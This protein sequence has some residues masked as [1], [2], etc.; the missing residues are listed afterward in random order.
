M[1]R[2]WAKLTDTL[3]ETALTEDLGSGDITTNATIASSL[4]S[5][6]YI[7]SKDSGVMAGI[8]VSMKVFHKVDNSLK[9]RVLLKDGEKFSNGQKI[10]EITGSVASIFKAERTALNFLGRI[11]GIATLTAKYVDKVQGCHAKILDTRKTMP[12]MRHLD[13]YAVRTGGGYN[14]RFGLYDRVLIKDNHIA[15]VGGIRIAVDRVLSHMKKCHKNTKIEVECNSYDEVLEAVYTPVDIIM[16]DNMD[17]SEIER[18]VKLINESNA[19][20]ERTIRIEIS[21][22]INLDTVRAVA[23]TGVDYISIGILTHSV[24]NSDFTLLFDEI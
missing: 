2:Q 23:E 14:H 12:T 7:F 11:T 18:T 9:T 6:A 20:N 4:E 17:L 22:N 24:K 13:K 10:A 21:G 16:L 5:T 19:E 15:V 1:E 3:I 8:D